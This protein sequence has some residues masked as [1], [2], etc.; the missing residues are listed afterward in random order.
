MLG[1][2][3]S[4]QNEIEETILALKS[5]VVQVEEIDEIREIQH[6]LEEMRQEVASKKL[7]VMILFLYLISMNFSMNILSMTHHFDGI[8]LFFQL[9]SLEGVLAEVQK[10]KSIFTDNIVLSIA[11]INNNRREM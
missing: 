2:I 8:Y 11:E 3:K 6:K 1:L 7:Q 10:K 9:S 4:R 5:E